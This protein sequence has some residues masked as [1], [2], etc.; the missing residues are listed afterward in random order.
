MLERQTV[1]RTEDFKGFGGIARRDD[2]GYWGI[3]RRSNEARPSKAAESRRE[4]KRLS[5]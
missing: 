5:L 4:P 1:W 3:S 2:D